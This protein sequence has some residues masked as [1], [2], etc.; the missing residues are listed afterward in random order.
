MRTFVFSARYVS[1][2]FNPRVPANKHKMPT[3]EGMDGIPCGVASIGAS[4]P[5]PPRCAREQ[6]P[7]HRDGTRADQTRR[8]TVA[9]RDGA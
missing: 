1:P 5:L 2:L 8:Q 7:R 9:R 3:G 4:L 6:K